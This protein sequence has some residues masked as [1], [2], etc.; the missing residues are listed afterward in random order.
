[1]YVLM[2]KVQKENNI[3]TYKIYLLGTSK[4]KYRYYVAM[5]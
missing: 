5:W 4:M 1:M 3:L 2:V